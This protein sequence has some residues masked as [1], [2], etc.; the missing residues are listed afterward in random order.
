MAAEHPSVSGVAGRYA[1]A[2]FELAREEKSVDAVKAD[3]DNFD[4]L[5]NESADLKRLV[6]SPVFS[7]GAQ[8]KALSAVLDKA[9]I[10]GTSAKF[11]KVLTGNRRLF[12]VAGV[13]R[14]YRALV[15]NFKGEAT[16]EVIVAEQLNDKNLDALKAALKSVT[17]KDVALNVKIDPSIIGGLVVKVGSRMV[18]SSL[19]TKLNSIKHAMKEAG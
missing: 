17:G 7:A 3:L 16:A 4:A 1:T 10:S 9:G 5:L 12:A 11:L 8:L 14:A 13:I 18:D 15:A 19:R 6:R 2:L